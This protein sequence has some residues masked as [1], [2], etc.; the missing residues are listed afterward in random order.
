MAHDWI[1]L[2]SDVA[3]D[4]RRLDY[5]TRYS[6]IPVT[7]PETVATHSYWVSV[8]SLLIHRQLMSGSVFPLDALEHAIL[9]KALFHD[10]AE[11]VTG[12]LVRTFKYSSVN[13]RKE[14]DLA[15]ESLA[16]RLPERVQRAFD[17]VGKLNDHD[18]AYVKD[19]VKAADFLSLMLYMN[20]ERM[21]GNRD[22]EPFE[23][24]MVKDLTSTA[25]GLGSGIGSGP[26]PPYLVELSNLY[27]CMVSQHNVFMPM[28]V[29]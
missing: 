29:M 21:R 11:C 26:V 15:E 4:V 2:I 10:A 22:V 3:T 23:A 17:P 20:R 14:A 1:G 18:R 12:D 13:L 9:V 24:R 5:V 28:G 16:K 6:S 8:Y 19:V 7:T 25:D 27:R